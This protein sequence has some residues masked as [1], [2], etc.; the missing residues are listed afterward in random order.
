MK[1][2]RHTTLLV[3][4]PKMPPV[5]RKRT[6]EEEEDDVDFDYSSLDE[7]SDSDI[8]ISSALVGKKPRLDRKRPAK[9]EDEDDE[10]DDP[11]AIYHRYRHHAVSDDEEFDLNDSASERAFGYAGRRSHVESDDESW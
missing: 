6:Q 11:M 8:D 3:Y 4:N 9:G 5:K 1:V 2:S 10:D 7:Q